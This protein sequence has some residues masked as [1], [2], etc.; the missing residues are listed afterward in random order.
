MRKA[1]LDG[2]S[3]QR[4]VVEKTGWGRGLFFSLPLLFEIPY[5]TQDAT[6]LGAPHH[7]CIIIQIGATSPLRELC[8][9]CA[10]SC[11][12]APT[13]P[14]FNDMR[15]PTIKRPDINV[16]VFFIFLRARIHRHT[17]TWTYKFTRASYARLGYKLH[18]Y[19][20]WP[21]NAGIPSSLTLWYGTYDV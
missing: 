3:R 11:D 6:D 5:W 21:E 17:Y 1:R 4:W 16:R 20:M 12:V 8:H 2:A 15:A 10:E 19:L 9:F 7:Y 14:S 13:F 18:V